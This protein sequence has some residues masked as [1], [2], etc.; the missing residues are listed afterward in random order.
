MVFKSDLNTKKQ[1]PEKKLFSMR[2]VQL[3]N[4]RLQKKAI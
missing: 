3:S 4:G 2:R 1:E